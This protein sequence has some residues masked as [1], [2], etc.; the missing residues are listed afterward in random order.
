MIRTLDK[1]NRTRA[2]ALGCIA[3]A[4]AALGQ[5]GE[6]WSQSRDFRGVSERTESIR[7]ASGSSRLFFAW[8]D[9]DYATFAGVLVLE[10]QR[11]P[12]A[13][14]RERARLL[15]EAGLAVAALGVDTRD[16]TATLASV[17]EA[18]AACDWLESTRETRGQRIAVVGIGTASTVAV[19]LAA[20]DVRISACA[21]DRRV[22]ELDSFAAGETRAAILVLPA[23]IEGAAP[24]GSTA[25]AALL[26]FLEKHLGP[27]ANSKDTPP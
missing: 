27:G 16:S 23:P 3:L 7:T 11:T 26:P 8:P 10:P 22:E 18:R 14:T 24:L 12:K 1:P 4:A 21:V 5:S 17:A 6:G 9:Q 20:S 15:A 13:K 25:L 19:A 2:L